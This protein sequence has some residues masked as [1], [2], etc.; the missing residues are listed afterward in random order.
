MIKISHDFNFIDK[1]LFAFVFTISAFFRECFYSIFLAIFILNDQIN[2][3]EVTFSNFFYR[4]EKL[5]ETSLVKFFTKVISPSK[6]LLGWIWVF[7]TERL[8][9]SFELE[10]MGMTKFGSVIFLIIKPF[11]I[12]YKIK[13]EANFQMY[14]FF[15][16]HKKKKYI[17]F[18][19]DVIWE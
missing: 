7:E 14:S 5:M 6:E 4:F 3:C 8:V 15:G 10:C 9:I 1:W 16:L 2:G 13:V 11:K 12:K 18:K 17:K 19:N